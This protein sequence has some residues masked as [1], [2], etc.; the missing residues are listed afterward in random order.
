MVYDPNYRGTLSAKTQIMNVDYNAF[1]GWP[2]EG[3]PSVVTVRG[4]VAVRDGKFVGKPGAANSCNG[5]RATFNSSHLHFHGFL[6][7]VEAITFVVAA[8]MV[9][10]MAF[11]AD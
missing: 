11:K 8:L 6:R 2:I 5:S 10:W 3:R 4:Q 7:P 9:A 1:E